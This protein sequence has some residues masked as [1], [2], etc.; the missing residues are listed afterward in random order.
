VNYIEPFDP[1]EDEQRPL[2]YEDW[3]SDE[4]FED[5]ELALTCARKGID[6]FGSNYRLHVHDQEIVE[7][8]L[9]K[10]NKCDFEAYE[11]IQT[12]PWYTPDWVLGMCRDAP[13]T[14][15]CFMAYADGL[16]LAIIETVPRA[17]V[18]DTWD[19]RT[20]DNDDHR[21]ITWRAALRREPRIVQKIDEW[22]E[23]EISDQPLLTRVFRENPKLY[24]GCR[25]YIRNLEF[26]AEVVF[27]H[28]G[29]QIRDS[30][31]VDNIVFAL[32]AVR[33]NGLALRWVSTRLQTNL[34]VMS[35]A[36]AQNGMAL[37]WVR[38][39]DAEVNQAAIR[40]NPAAAIFAYT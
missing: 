1:K 26:V 29:L 13:E 24:T 5:R 18:Y 23:L 17:H 6:P 10:C 32:I 21:E 22:C 20:F 2:E 30:P 7:A 33:Q 9:K 36:V 19:N 38:C 15:Q 28:D 25:D 14:A 8:F 39:A 3:I 35:R 16:Q 11:K 4:M 34:V 40:Q 31:F 12:S 37:A 27:S